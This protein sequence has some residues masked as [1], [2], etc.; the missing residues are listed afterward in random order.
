LKETYGNRS[1]DEATEKIEYYISKNKLAPH[2]KLPSERD[3][4]TMWDFNRTT[5][6]SAIQRLI[7]ENKLYQ[8]K[9][10]GTYVAEP[11][12]LRN[13]QDLRSL[14]TLVEENGQTLSNEILSSEVIESNKQ[15]SQKLHLSLGCKV[16]ALTRL[17]YIDGEAVT[18]ESSFISCDK[19]PTIEK[20]DFSKESLYS[21]MEKHYNMQIMQGEERVGIAYA[22]DYEAELLGLEEGRAVFYLTGVVYD[23]QGEPI[24][25]FKSIVKENKM[26]FVSTLKD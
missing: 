18:I 13:L 25:Y 21:V 5:L 10:S 2:T 20:C 23:G 11:K 8:K 22:T 14:S 4:C 1:R 3:L 26:R 6:R 12:L 24:E 9:G 16:Y 15:I 17:R 7:V 19:F